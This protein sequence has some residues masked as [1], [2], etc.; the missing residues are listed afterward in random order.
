MSGETISPNMNLPIPAVGVTQG[1]V[2]AQDVNSCLNIIDGHTHNPGYGAQITSAALNISADLTFGGNSAINLKSTRYTVQTSPLSG[3]LDLGCTYVS[4]VDLYFNDENGNQIQVTQNGGIAGSPGSISNLTSPASAS[5][6]AGN[7]TFVWQSAANTPASMDG[8]SV[9]LRNIA[10][11]SKGLTLAPPNAM[12]ADYTITLPA[13]PASQKFMTLDAS[14][15]ASAPWA[16]DNSTLEISLNTLRVKAGGIT[17]NEL[18]TDVAIPVGSIFMLAWGGPPTG[19]LT[20]DGSAVSRTTYSVLYGRIGTTNGIGN[21]STTFNLPDYRGMFPRGWAQG[22]ANDPDRNSRTAAASGA[23]TGDNPG[24]IQSFAVES[25]THIQT[26][27]THTQT[28]HNHAI[29][30]AGHAHTFGFIQAG[31]ATAGGAV[32]TTGP[33]TTTTSTTVTGIS[34]NNTTAVNQN[35]T[36]VNGSYG[37][38][39]TRPINIYA[40]FIIK[41]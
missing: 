2:Y 20:C 4:G 1:P 25:H 22:S 29:T 37:S 31:A 12:G 38:S 16:V 11:S 35:T 18:A 3:A 33:G 27:H 21:G 40:H 41:Y 9:I 30:D 23:N 36:A 13:L 17:T 24:S 15:N 6:V 5:Y 7:S 34:I 8:G 39:E 10:A 14:G 19:W 32:T 28:A 26:A